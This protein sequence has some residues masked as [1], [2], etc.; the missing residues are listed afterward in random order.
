MDKLIQLLLDKV[1]IKATE[2]V[3]FGFSEFLTAFALLIIVWTTV[4]EK[5]NFRVKTAPLPLKGLSFFSI[6]F[7]G[8]FTLVLD[9]M[10]AKEY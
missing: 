4:D 8:L 1:P 2:T 6:S 10:R 5:Y 7:I 9:V 3:F